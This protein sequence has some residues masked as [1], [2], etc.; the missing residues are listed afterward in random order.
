MTPVA[1]ASCQPAVGNATFTLV[2]KA[3]TTL[4]PQYLHAHQEATAVQPNGWAQPICLTGHEW[5][6]L[7][8]CAKAESR[9]VPATRRFMLKILTHSLAPMAARSP[10]RQY[11]SWLST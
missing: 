1:V 10:A 4:A 9:P 5:V 3:T 6:G 11:M 2:D 7:F 8:W